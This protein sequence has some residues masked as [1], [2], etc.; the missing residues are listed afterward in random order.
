MN[1][2]ED[3]N[4]ISNLVNSF[5]LKIKED[6]LLGNIFELHLAKTWSEHLDKMT[7]F[8]ETNLL[9]VAK[10]KGNPT[11]KHIQV[12]NNINHAIEQKHFERWLQLWFETIDELF[13]GE[14]AEKAKNAARKMSIGQFWAIWQHRN[15]NL[16][17][18]KDS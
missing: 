11:Q 9:G 17:E 4:D 5:Y 13:T 15:Q 2:I 18:H 8:W 3:R 16:L 6:E 12:D 7:D 1:T 14:C 10:F